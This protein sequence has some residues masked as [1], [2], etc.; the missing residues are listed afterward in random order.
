[1]SKCQNINNVPEAFE[2]LRMGL[3]EVNIRGMGLDKREISMAGYY[4]LF[5]ALYSVR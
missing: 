4:G 3:S 5:D 2:A 1:M